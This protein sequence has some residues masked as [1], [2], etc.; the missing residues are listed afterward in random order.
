MEN[1]HNSVETRFKPGMKVKKAVKQ[2][3]KVESDVIIIQAANNNVSSTILQESCKETTEVLREIQKNNPKAKICLSAAFGRKDSNELNA[4]VFKLHKLLAETLPL[5]GIDIIENNS[6]LFSKWKSDSLHLN[7][8][9]IRIYVSNLN[10]FI[11][12]D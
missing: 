8:G 4:K 2:T 6:I 9:K 7:N 12:Y 10:K 5:N 1:E 3:G 11:K